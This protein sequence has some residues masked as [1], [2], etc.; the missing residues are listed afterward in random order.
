MSQRTLGA[1]AVSAA[2]SVLLMTAAQAFAAGHP[3]CKENNSCKGQAQSCKGTS[4]KGAHGCKGQNGC[5]NNVPEGI[6]DEAACK[7]IT[8]ATWV[9]K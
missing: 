6:K 4:A 7:A 9:A 2:T 1:I 5:K 3:H 8:G